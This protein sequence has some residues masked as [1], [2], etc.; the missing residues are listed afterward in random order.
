[1][2]TTHDML[3]KERWALMMGQKFERFAL[4][5]VVPQERMLKGCVHRSWTCATSSRGGNV[6]T[7]G[8][9]RTIDLI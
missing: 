7:T 8:T 1:M 6:G 2:P 9:Q 3:M 5:K 4:V